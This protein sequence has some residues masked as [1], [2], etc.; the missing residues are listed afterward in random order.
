[1]TPKAV[2][3]R[4]GRLGNLFPVIKSATR[5]LYLCQ[6][7]RKGETVM[8][9]RFLQISES[10]RGRLNRKQPQLEEAGLSVSNR[11]NVLCLILLWSTEER[12]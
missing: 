12:R 2:V 7:E 3:K 9:L 6:M 5:S 8:I 4:R 11:T 1:M 10:T